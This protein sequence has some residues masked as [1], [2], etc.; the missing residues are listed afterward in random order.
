MSTRQATTASYRG[1]L[2]VVDRAVLSDAGDL[3]RQVRMRVGRRRSGPD[4]A[5]STSAAAAA[6]PTAAAAGRHE[7][8]V[9]GRAPQFEAFLEPSSVRPSVG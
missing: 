6:S 9:G 8:R 1:G 5:P 3:R 2:V 7:E 4:D